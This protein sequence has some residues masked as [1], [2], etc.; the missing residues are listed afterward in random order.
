MRE[1]GLDPARTSQHLEALIA[2]SVRE[3]QRDGAIVGLSGGIDSAVVATLAARALGPNQVL[4]L[5]LPERDSVPQSKRDGLSLA[6]QLGIRHKVVGLTKLLLLMGTYWKVPLWV[7]GLRRFQASMVRRYY[8]E[9]NRQLGEYETPF[10]AVMVGTQGLKGP[11]INQ[12]VAYHRVKVRLRMVLLYYYAELE[13]L[14]VIGTCNKTELSVGFFVKWGDAAA[15]IAPLAS[16]Y[17][18]QVRQ[19]ATYLE[20]PEEI[21]AKPPSPDILPGLTD[22]YALG[23]EYEVLDKILWRMESGWEDEA[24]ATELGLKPGMVEYVRTL[25]ERSE[26]MRTPSACSSS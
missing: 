21:I 22:E 9:F 7:L 1:L 23:I 6:R 19:L 2:K 17:K 12:A 13:N 26:H 24:I 20:V 8:E 11:W 18:T 15:D 10:S 25:V 3:L 5:I 14:L 16:L 4:G